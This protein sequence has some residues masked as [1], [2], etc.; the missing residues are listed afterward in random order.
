MLLG[1]QFLVVGQHMQTKQPD[2][3]WLTK[4][5]NISCVLDGTS[6]LKWLRNNGILSE[7]MAQN[8]EHLTRLS[9]SNRKVPFQKKNLPPITCLAQIWQGKKVNPNIK[10]I[11]NGEQ[12]QNHCSFE[13]KKKKESKSLV[14]H[15]HS[16]WC[17][18]NIINTLIPVVA[19]L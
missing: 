19:H 6:N 13:A 3:T 17:F 4:A 16:G 18:N 10:I 15:G 7:V 1:L 12:F 2:V 14:L 9:H 8:A 11:W 5:G